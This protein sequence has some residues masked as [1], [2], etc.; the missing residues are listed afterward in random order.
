[1]G[2]NSFLEHFFLEVGRFEKRI[3][4]SEKKPLLCTATK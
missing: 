4:L 3:K 2:G 1:M